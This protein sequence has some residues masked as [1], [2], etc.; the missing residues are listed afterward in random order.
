L[1]RLKSAFEALHAALFVKLPAG[2]MSAEFP[3]G[4]F[5][6]KRSFEKPP[7]GRFSALRASDEKSRDGRR[8]V[9]FTFR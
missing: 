7:K 4:T 2:F 9:L 3:F 8:G 1:R 6:K 5:A